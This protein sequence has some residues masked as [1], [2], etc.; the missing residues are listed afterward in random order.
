MQKIAVITSI[1]STIAQAI[2]KRL[3]SEGYNIIVTYENGFDA[4]SKNRKHLNEMSG[5]SDNIDYHNVILSKESSVNKFISDINSLKLD[6][7]VNCAAELSFHSNGNLRH[8]FFSFNFNDFNSVLAVNLTS[9]AAICIGLKNTIKKG[10]CIINITSSAAEE[11]GFATISY[12]ASKAAMKSLTQSLANNFGPYNGV[13]VN[14][15]AP[16]WIPPKSNVAEGSIVDLANSLT[17]NRLN[18]RPENVANAV[19]HIIDQPFMTGSNYELDG[20]I[21]SSY[22]MYLIESLDL[23]S[24]KTDETVQKITALVK[25]IQNGLSAQ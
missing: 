15:I 21:T 12:N 2:C 20:G 14:S 22:L 17:P 13:R 24:G 5:N 16:G 23:K 18:G 8:E 1:E 3:T 19:M 25:N 4:N 11:G 7:I 9:T 10:G 6:L